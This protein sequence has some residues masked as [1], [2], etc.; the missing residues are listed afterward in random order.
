MR[1][2]D[3]YRAVFASGVVGAYGGEVRGRLV[4]LLVVAAGIA[5]VAVVR[6]RKFTENE[7]NWQRT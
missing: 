6:E 5:L 3:A 2:T 7:R 1:V 4:R